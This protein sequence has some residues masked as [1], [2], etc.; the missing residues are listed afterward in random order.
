MKQ[1]IT[2][3][4]ILFVSSPIINAQAECQQEPPS[5]LSPLAAY[6]IFYENYKS[7][8]YEFALDYGRWMTCAK[9]ETIE[10]NPRFSLLTQYERLVKI[11][12]EVGRS[13]DDPTIKAAYIDTAE[14]LLNEAIELFGDNPEDKFDIVFDRGRF[15]QQNYNII[16]GGLDKAYNDYVMLFEIDPERAANMGNGYYLRQALNHLVS[17]DR[18]EDAQNLIDTVSPMVSGELAD[19][20]GEKQQDILG[21]PQERVAYF[22]PLLEND[23]NNLDALKALEGAY[24]S[25]DQRDKLNEVKVK[26]NELEPTYESA[27]SLAEFDRSNANYTEAITF[28]EQA[29]ERADT[30]DQRKTVYLRLADMNINIENLQTAKRYV[31]QALQIDPNDGNTIIK[32]ATIY[33]AAVTKCTEGRKLEAADKV[34]YWVVIDYLNKAKSVD[35]SVAGTVNQQL[36]TYEDVSPNSEDK[37]FTL[38]LEDGDTIRVDGSLRDCYSWINESTTVR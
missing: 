4:G 33:G 34:V 9:P 2:L 5:G 8:D 23:P 10:G 1:L 26:I 11:Y 30:D 18:K 28:Y 29:L 14:T 35:P 27:Y 21:S 31:Q 32:M 17:E 20:L 7:G 38:N 15:Y 24:E 6:S 37:F 19:F 13:K 3:L 22:E 25:L 16:D 36:S 12:D